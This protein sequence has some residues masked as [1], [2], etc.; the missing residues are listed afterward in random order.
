MER[1]KFIQAFG[2]SPF[3]RTID[4][5]PI[6]ND[7]P[8]KNHPTSPDF[9]YKPITGWAADFIPLYAKGRFELF[10]LLDFRNSEKH[11]EGTP[12]YRIST[13]NFVNY[14]EHG[15]AIPRGSKDDQDLFIF[16]G[17]ALEANGRFHIFYT[18]H[19]HHLSGK[20]KPQQAVMHAVSDDLKTWKKIPENTFYAPVE[21]YE[22]HDWRDPFVYWN[23]E[24]KEYNMLLAARFKKGISRRRGLT[25]FCTSKDLIKWEVKDPFYAPDLYFTHECPDLFKMGDWWYL[26]FSE[27]TDKV[28][29]RYVMSKSMNG[30]WIIPDVDDFDGHAFYAAKTAADNK[31][32]F[33]FGWNPTRGD[34]KDDGGWQWGGNLVVHELHQDKNGSLLVRAPQTVKDAFNQKLNIAWTP[35]TGKIDTKENKVAL[36][37]SGSFAA[38]LAQEV[39]RICRITATCKFQLRAK[40]FGILFYTTDDVEKSYYIRVEP[41]SKRVVF[42]RWPRIRA[43]VPHMAEFERPLTLVKNEVF[44]E[45]FIEGTKGVLY[46]DDSV[47]MN[48]RCYDFTSGKWGLFA[49]DADVVFSNVAISTML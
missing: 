41:N 8:Q 40:E 20:G 9:F 5:E 33:L 11:G 24:S 47:A 7:I 22:M 16:T 2:V 6:D 17:S 42:D 26:I 44:L 28:K 32:R 13:N 4:F 21:K 12:W 29:T 15:E 1:R 45:L 18:G 30:P 19:N 46:V 43:E 35:L 23:E 25:A 3:L 49:T 14:E 27:F 34:N 39:P 10:Y 36:T 38:A 48:F 37:A 31:K